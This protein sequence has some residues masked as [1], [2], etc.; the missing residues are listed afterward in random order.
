MAWGGC[1]PAL[2]RAWR[3]AGTPGTHARPPAS[4]AGSCRAGSAGLRDWCC[5]SIACRVFEALVSLLRGP[6]A[7]QERPLNPDSAPLLDQMRTPGYE[8]EYAGRDGTGRGWACQCNY[9]NCCRHLRRRLKPASGCSRLYS[10]IIHTQC[11]LMQSTRQAN[12]N[13]DYPHTAA[14][15]QPKT[16][17]AICSESDEGRH[18]TCGT[19]S[20]GPLHAAWAR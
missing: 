2:P 20:G 4:P 13:T 3:P 6:T 15:T 1:P 11:P 8:R 17:V 19:P 16:A 7:P 9:D 10:I 12:A 14:D 5:S 18:C